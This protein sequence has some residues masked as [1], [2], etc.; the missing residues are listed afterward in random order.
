[1]P[2]PAECLPG[3]P[4]QGGTL[5]YRLP[6]RRPW[7]LEP[8]LTSS[9]AG[10]I[11]SSTCRAV[12]SPP[13]PPPAPRSRA[14]CPV[15]LGAGRE[16]CAPVSP[17][18]V[19]TKSRAVAPREAGTPGGSLVCVRLPSQSP[20]A[21]YQGAPGT[22]GQHLTRL[23]LRDWQRGVERPDSFAAPWHPQRLT[24]AALALPTLASRASLRPPLDCLPVWAWG[25]QSRVTL[26]QGPTPGSH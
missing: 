8:L 6:W 5:P 16:L 19:H 9:R 14:V 3:L 2:H 4:A 7:D 15:C 10:G 25:A 24:G 18:S 13:P 11:S 17:G 26:A 20:Q 21:A 23:C 22:V 12:S 1:M